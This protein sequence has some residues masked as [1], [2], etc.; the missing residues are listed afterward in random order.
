MSPCKFQLE[1][2]NLKNL[3]KKHIKVPKTLPFSLDFFLS[4]YRAYLS[5]RFWF[6]RSHSFEKRTVETLNDQNCKTYASADNGLKA[7]TKKLATI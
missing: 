5:M 4:D 6:Q 7:I 1:N 3:L 2:G